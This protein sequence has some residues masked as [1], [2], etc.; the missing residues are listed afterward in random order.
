MSPS[1][2]PATGQSNGSLEYED[3]PLLI[4]GIKS[5]NH[6]QAGLPSAVETTTPGHALGGDLAKLFSD[7]VVLKIWKTAVE[8]IAREDPPQSFPET[9]PQTGPQA[10]QY[11]YRDAEFWTCGF[12]PGSLYCL[13]ER[14]VRYPQA[15]LAEAGSGVRERERL[16]TEL[17]AVCRTWSEPLHDMAGRKDT[18]DIG[19]IVEPALRRDYELTGSARS[20]ASLVRAAE[21]LASRYSETTKAI[22]SWDRFVN[23]GNNFV[24]K[25]SE[26]LLIIDSMCNLD[27]LYYAGH[28]V[29]SQRLIDIAT[30]HAHTIRATHLRPEPSMP[31]SSDPMYSTCHVANVC[32]LT[33]RVLQR[34]TAQGYAAASTWSR[35]QAW[36]ILGFA[37]TYGWTGDAT[38]LR[39]ACGLADY[40]LLRLREAPACVEQRRVGR[41]VPLWDFDAPVDE[42]R[43]LRD[44]SAGVIAANGM[45]LIAHAAAASGDFARF[46]KY[47]RAATTI[48]DET[49][50][51]CYAKDTLELVGQESGA[52]G[53]GVVARRASG[54]AE[55][56]FDCI[57]KCATANF[58]E[59]WTDRYAD[60]GLVYADYYLLEFGNRLLQF[61]YA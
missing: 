61:G 47:Y 13:L 9:C 42:A 5:K 17:L 51:L 53:V 54:C 41:H 49:M 11:Q 14:S 25:E 2:L 7:N 55:S 50:A 34:L 6:S 16:R 32:P 12:F 15:F 26:F 29:S 40:F 52:G 37:Q 45:L 57:L 8:H 48:V 21:S 23:N 44:T 19:F 36:A 58:N 39:T 18:H 27:L 46:E 59:N 28:H 24:D 60:H 31:G 4:D 10:G 1:T 30:S 22:R 56:R 35:G 33:G 20:F 43:P 38:F 3:V